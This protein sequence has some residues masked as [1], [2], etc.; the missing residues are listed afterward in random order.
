MSFG[1]GVATVLL[2]GVGAN[3]LLPGRPCWTEAEAVSL[4]GSTIVTLFLTGLLGSSLLS[5]GNS[6]EQDKRNAVR[7][8][9]V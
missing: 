2:P 3:M 1:D 7:M 5:A 6:S 9:V 4:T 8:K